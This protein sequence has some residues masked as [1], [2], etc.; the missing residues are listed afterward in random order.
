MIGESQNR[1][2]ESSFFYKMI[3]ICSHTTSTDMKKPL[4]FILLLLVFF[5]NCRNTTAQQEK[6]YD[7]YVKVV[8]ITDG[9]TFKGLTEDSVLI[10]FRIYGID[11]PEKKQAFGTKSK[12]KLS[13]LIFGK[14]VGI[15]VQT[16]RDFYGRPVVWVFTPEGKDVSGIMLQ[17]GLA[18]HYKKYDHTPEYAEMECKAKEKKKGLWADAQAIA[19]WDFRKKTKSK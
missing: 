4:I 13:E 16:E 14:R 9:D 5:T 7:Y 12:E 1:I 8:G 17:S 2:L 15:K 19:P 6:K 18:W 3:Y 10:R 11:A